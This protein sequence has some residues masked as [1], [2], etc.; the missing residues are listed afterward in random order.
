M[1][2]TIDIDD[3]LLQR[4]RGDAHRL[5]IP[6]RA[7]L[8]RVLQRGLD[9]STPDAVMSYR[10]PSVRLGAVGVG[11]NLVKALQL[12]AALD[13]DDIARTQREGP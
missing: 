10:T 3:S 7:M 11:V 4:L 2:T 6:F 9:E 12:S 1:R 5:G 13:D 8:H